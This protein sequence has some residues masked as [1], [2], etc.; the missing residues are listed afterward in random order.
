MFNSRLVA[1]LESHTV[2]GGEGVRDATGPGGMFIVVV[3][4]TCTGGIAPRD[5]QAGHFS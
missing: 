3:H 1:A 5:E 4:R 2:Q